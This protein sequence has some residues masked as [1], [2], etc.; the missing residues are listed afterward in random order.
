L[1]YD[2]SFLDTMTEA[3]RWYYVS[4]KFKAFS[5]KP[6]AVYLDMTGLEE[7]STIR[8]Y[9]ISLKTYPEPIS[10][11]EGTIKFSVSVT[12]W[13]W[14][15]PTS[16]GNTL[17][18]VFSIRNKNSYYDS[19]DSKGTIYGFNDTTVSHGF[20]DIWFPAFY[21]RDSG[22]NLKMATG[23][24]AI[25]LVPWFNF[26]NTIN[27]TGN[28]SGFPVKFSVVVQM[29]NDNSTQLL[30]DPI[31]NFNHAYLSV[32]IAETPSKA[33][34]PKGIGKTG[35]PVSAVVGILALACLTIYCVYKMY[36]RKKEQTN[37]QGWMRGETYSSLA[38]E[39]EALNSFGDEVYL[40]SIGQ[41]SQ[42]QLTIN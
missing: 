37:A 36:K 3:D 15:N 13:S 18:L 2:P 20:Y 8:F 24:P 29:E 26:N 32:P 38:L 5:E 35:P 10:I 19:K 16:R 30:Y 25:T 27:I 6:L 34:P 9:N 39:E 41:T 17:D 23:Y 31:V 14:T 12:N 1:E 21:N 22:P 42:R 40:G 33:P 4:Y 11:E 28:R 7:E